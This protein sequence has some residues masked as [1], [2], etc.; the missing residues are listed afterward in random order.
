MAQ[1]KIVTNDSGNTVTYAGKTLLDQESYELNKFEWVR[2]SNDE[3]I[4]LAISSGDLLVSNGVEN[5]NSDLGLAHIKNPAG[6]VKEHSDITLLPGFGENAPEI[7]EV[8]S[9][10]IGFCMQESD[11]IYG[12]TRFNNY[13]GGDVNFQLH[14]AIDNSVVDRWIQFEVN[15]WTTN[16]FNDKSANVISQ[17]LQMGPIEVPA[18]PW[19][20]FEAN[21]DIPSSYFDSGEK[22]FFVS[23]K[24]VAATGKTAPIN[25]PVVFRYCKEFFKVDES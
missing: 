21:V 9:A 18:T 24:R 13:V 17:T 12:Q 10:L 11:K 1:R 7:T 2:W 22:Y 23:V 6:I 15:F 19:L 20:I 4:H 25:H 14:L 5:F 3:D 8:S 16:G